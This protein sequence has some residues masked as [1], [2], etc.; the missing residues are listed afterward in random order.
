MIR[1]PRVEADAKEL[2]GVT[3]SQNAVHVIPMDWSAAESVFSPLVDRID[4]ARSETQ[5]LV[6]TPDGESASAAADRLVS[7]AGDR[8]ISVLP[9]TGGPRASRLLRTM[10]AHIVTG[11][12]AALV[13]L[14]QASALKPAGV[15]VVV[16]AWLDPILETPDATPL[17][18]LLGELPKEGARVVLASELTPAY[19]ALIE[20]YARRA[21]RSVEG[22]ETLVPIS[23]EYITTSLAAR[24][25]TLRRLLDALDLPRAE[26]YARGPEARAEAARVVRALGY[27]S[28][29]IR[30]V[31]TATESTDPL[32]LLELPSSRSE[33]QA[34]AAAG[35]RRVYAIVQANQLKSLNAMFGGGEL[36][37]IS[38]IDA[39]ERARGRDASLRASLREL[40]T[41][42]DVR[43]EVLALEP[44]LDEF[45]GIEIAAATLRLLEQQRPER[46]KDP[47]AA[48]TPMQRLFMNV[49]ERDGARATEI[50]KLIAS[51]AGI[52]GS[53]IGRIE[54]RD[55]HSIVEVAT[56]VAELVVSKITGTS[57]RG[58]KVQ[59][60]VD[61][62]RE[63]GDREDRP[64]GP[65]SDSDRGPRGPRGEGGDRPRGPRREGGDRGPRPP[66]PDAPRGATRRFDRDGG[67]RPS[68]PRPRR[69]DA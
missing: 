30:V 38:L 69:D 28:D 63:R 46:R 17:E 52:P 9:A 44:L 50:V 22:D 42:G 13:S 66:R 68:R 40:L 3:R 51:E 16:F 5:M 55:T 41:S 58:R 10:P 47:V 18:T 53:Q 35:T 21:R 19:E 7:V 15:K 27:P 39:A 12:P 31:T 59:A 1:E 11:A 33:L 23:G 20:R 54:V 8:A 36:T 6:L 67:G 29:A 45:D 48:V 49:G 2:P 64:R 37:P 43:R 14:L 26:V 56:T 34:L 62:P 24:G 57:V 61:K 25:T 32:V 4:P 60:R 65:R